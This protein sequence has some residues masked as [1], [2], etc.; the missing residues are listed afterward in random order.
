MKTQNAQNQTVSTKIQDLKK[1]DQVGFHGEVFEIIEDAINYGDDVYV[2]NC[3]IVSQ[4]AP[5]KISGLLYTY[6]RFQGNG[7]ATQSVFV[8]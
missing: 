6:D 1:G 2:A 5:G 8:K 7:R 3:R 4:T